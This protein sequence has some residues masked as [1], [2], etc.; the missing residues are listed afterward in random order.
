MSTRNFLYSNRNVNAAEATGELVVAGPV[1]L[2]AA[3][4]CTVDFL[5][6]TGAFAAAVW[7]LETS[8]DGSRWA[9]IDT[10]LVTGGVATQT[11]PGTKNIR[12]S[13]SGQ[14]GLLRARLS[15]AEGS[16]GT[17]LIVFNVH[18]QDPAFVEPA[19]VPS[20]YAPGAG[21][22][23]SLGV[24]GGGGGGGAGGAPSSSGGGGGG[25]GSGA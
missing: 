16:P 12:P 21:S 13:K 6:E 22:G 24:G 8:G 2:S 5:S 10:A 20:A 17:C 3:D 9:T 15:G 11:G 25:V 1:P 7:T 14:I 18:T 23:A 4:G 19:P